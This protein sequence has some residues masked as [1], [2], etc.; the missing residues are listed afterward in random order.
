MTTPASVLRRTSREIESARFSVAA[1]LASGWRTFRRIVETDQAFARMRAI[2]REDPRVANLILDRIRPLLSSEQPRDE[3]SRDAAIAAY[4]WVLH[5]EA[6]DH[7]RIG[8]GLISAVPS[9]WWAREAAVRLLREDGV[10]SA[11]SVSTTVVPADVNPSSPVPAA[12]HQVATIVTA[13]SLLQLASK[14]R[15]CAALIANTRSDRSTIAVPWGPPALRQKVLGS[16]TA[17][18]ART[19][20]WSH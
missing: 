20:E 9:L 18:A 7:A 2:V 4:L 10:T 12:A 5:L 17:V 14:F 8:A 16:G 3:R 6:P 1:N 13:F 19:V 11:A 15:V